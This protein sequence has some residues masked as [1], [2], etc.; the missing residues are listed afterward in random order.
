MWEN[1]CVVTIQIKTR[2]QLKNLT[3]LSYNLKKTK[4]FN[5]FKLQLKKTKRFKPCALFLNPM[6]QT[7]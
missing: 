5:P 4:K 2:K 3:H 6:S 1:L 7:I